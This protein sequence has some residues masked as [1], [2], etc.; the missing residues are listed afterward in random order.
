MMLGCTKDDSTMLEEM[1]QDTPDAWNHPLLLPLIFIELQSRKLGELVGE[2]I[3]F[4]TEISHMV[5]TISGSKYS[6]LPPD[7]IDKACENRV[8]SSIIQE[9]LARASRQ[10]ANIISH[11]ECLLDPTSDS[12]QFLAAGGVDTNV[13]QRF[14][15]RFKELDLDYQDLIADCKIN[16]D[17]AALFLDVVSARLEQV[18]TDLHLKSSICRAPMSKRTD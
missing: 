5:R 12:S 17:Q 13:T 1:L 4:A 8:R 10:M 7:L 6:K 11:C 9:D 2:V 16:S 15:A 14:F 3:D 18:F